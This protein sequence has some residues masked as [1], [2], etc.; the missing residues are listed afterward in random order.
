MQPLNTLDPEH[1]RHI[2]KEFHAHH[3]FCFRI[4]DLMTEVMRQSEE[5]RIANVKIKFDSEDEARSF[6]AAEDI[7]QFL[8][9]SGRAD[10]A[11]RL[12]LNQVVIPLYAD[13]L[14]FIYEGLRTLEKHKFTVSFALF[15]KPLKYSLFFATWLFA[16]EDDFFAR[17]EKSPADEMDESKISK[18]RR[19]EF[20]ESAIAKIDQAGFFDATDMYDIVFNRAK[21]NGLAPY[22][23]MAA[24]LVTSNNA[25]RT[26]RLNFNFIFKNPADT[27][28][29]EG[30]YYPLAYTLMYLFLLEVNT[31]GRMTTIS[32]AYVLWATMTMLGTFEAL[33]R[34]G[35]TPIIDGLDE[36]LRSYLNCIVCKRGMHITRDNGPRF[37]MTERI[38]CPTCG[39]EQEFPLFWL[40]SQYGAGRVDGAEA[41]T[42]SNETDDADEKPPEPVTT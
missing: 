35:E 34:D 38:D 10:I 12:V 23:D 26:D 40:I 8:V 32:D 4:H 7:H 24:H 36:A 9:D 25:L 28:T 13:M 19:V 33:F 37:L 41:P 31:M 15:R 2:P 27:D 22:F 16:D 14:H 21:A 5:A 42:P 6:A 17:L 39:Q 1:L 30:I 3:E 11:K 29:Y 20:L 18:E